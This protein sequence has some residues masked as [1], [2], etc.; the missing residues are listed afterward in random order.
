M[1]IWTVSRPSSVSFSS[2]EEASDISFP[3]K[4]CF[5]LNFKCQ[6]LALSQILSWCKLESIDLCG[7]ISVKDLFFS[8]L[9]NTAFAV[10]TGTKRLW[11]R[12]RQYYYL[13]CIIFD[14]TL[15]CYFIR[16]LYFTS[17]LAKIWVCKLLVTENDTFI[18]A[19]SF[20]TSYTSAKGSSLLSL[21]IITDSYLMI[22]VL[23]VPR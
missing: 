6:V 17:S 20:L 3:Q 18:S 1:L 13:S 5:V 16:K 7:F 23:Q 4:V 22:L 19:A 12:W 21:R 15:C 8:Y 11:Q 10:E 2:P 9:S 14:T